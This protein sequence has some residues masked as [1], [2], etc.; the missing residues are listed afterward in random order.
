MSS[1]KIRRFDPSTIKPHRII[2]II[3]RRGSGK[4]TLLRD[5]LYHMRNNIDLAIGFCPTYESA[6]MMRSCM[7]HGCVFDRLVPSKIDHLVSMSQELAA[8]GK[9]RSVAVLCDDCMAERGSFKSASLRTIFF[10]GRHLKVSLLSCSQ[11]VCDIG[12]DLRAQVDYVFALKDNVLANK[13]KLWRMFFGCFGTFDDFLAVFDR[14][15]Q[16]FECLVLDNTLQ[17]GDISSCCSWYKASTDLPEFRIGRPLFFEID[18]RARHP[19][20]REPPAS[21]DPEARGRA[22]LTIIKEGQEEDEAAALR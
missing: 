8:K 10:N 14:C 22:R 16:N 2:M 20:G 1:C 21:Q 12:P 13:A 15:T 19:P 3:A 18:E 4:S 6:A 5:L 11:Y 9:A 7:P 17:S